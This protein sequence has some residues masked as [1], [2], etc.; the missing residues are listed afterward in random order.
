MV[1]GDFFLL[2]EIRDLDKMKSKLEIIMEKRMQWY[3]STEVCSVIT[4]K[5][6]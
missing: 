1:A 3:L 5:I 4:S 2:L 6:S